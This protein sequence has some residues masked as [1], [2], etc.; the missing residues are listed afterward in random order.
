MPERL[1]FIEAVPESAAQ[2]LDAGSIH[3]W[4]IPYE[5]S[6][7]RGPLRELLAAYMGKPVTGVR[8]VEGSRGKPQLAIAGAGHAGRGQPLEFNWSHSGGYALVAISSRL[9]LGVDVERLG[10]KLRAIELA[11]RYFDPA[12]A[13]ALASLGPPARERAFVGLWCAKEAVLKAVGEGLS[14]GLARL[15]FAWC[16]DMEWKLVRADSALGGPDEWQLIGFDAAKGYRGALAWRGT[17][18]NIVAF[19]PPG[20]T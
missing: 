5:P 17:N 8:F 14:F 18:R 16:G 15:V 3:L 13:E 2:R 6:L 12:E 20:A 11:C 4:R 9:P 10:K 19:R 7:R 1:E